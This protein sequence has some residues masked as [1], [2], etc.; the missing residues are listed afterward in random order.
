[1]SISE[2][3]DIPNVFKATVI[4]KSFL[5]DCFIYHV[6][7]GDRLLKVK[8]DTRTRADVDQNVFLSI[9]PEDVIVL[10]AE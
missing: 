5:G 4:N 6:H 8:A 3:K 2:R 7:A 10:A 9:H 1:M